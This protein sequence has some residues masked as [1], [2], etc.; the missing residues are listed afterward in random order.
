MKKCVRM[1]SL[2]T[3]SY[4]VNDCSELI[5]DRCKS[6]TCVNIRHALNTL[7]ALHF[8][9]SSYRQL[10]GKGIYGSSNSFVFR[11]TNTIWCVDVCQ[12][13]YVTSRGRDMSHQVVDIVAK[14]LAASS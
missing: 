12:E 14:I 8:L 6:L 10:T 4:F 2:S 1:L 5:S 3:P 13:V 9:R 11:Q 7:L